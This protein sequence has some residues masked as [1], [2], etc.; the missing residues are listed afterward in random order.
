MQMRDATRVVQKVIGCAAVCALGEER[1]QERGRAGRPDPERGFSPNGDGTSKEEAL[2]MKH[3]GKH[4][5]L[6]L[7]AFLVVGPVFGTVTV[8]YV[9]PQASGSGSGESWD[10]ACTLA[11]ALGKAV[12]GDE[13]HLASGTYACS[14]TEAR[15]TAS[16]GLRSAFSSITRS[17]GRTA[18]RAPPPQSRSPAGIRRRSTAS[19][20]ATSRRRPS[21]P[22]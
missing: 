15:S 18:L 7:A 19:S 2:K 11:V 10:D 9:K 5:S 13:I 17:W 4:V 3:L 16:C 8:C 21:G 1:R 22:S 6:A 14:G 12:S 20:S